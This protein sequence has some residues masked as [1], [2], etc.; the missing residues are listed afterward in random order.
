MSVCEQASQPVASKTAAPSLSSSSV[1]SFFLLASFFSRC[2]SRMR[3]RSRS[4]S[5]PIHTVQNE[6]YYLKPP[7]R[8][9]WKLSTSQPLS[10][11][12]PRDPSSSWHALQY[13]STFQTPFHPPL[14]RIMEMK[15]RRRH[16]Q[17]HNTYIH[18]LEGLGQ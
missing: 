2:L 3:C 10:C 11:L 12:C 1:E 18:K 16:L 8:H 13:A 9:V 5:Y 4:L 7:H 17:M 15:A 14:Y 6:R